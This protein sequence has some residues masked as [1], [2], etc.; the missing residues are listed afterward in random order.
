[1]SDPDYS[2]LSITFPWACR[3]ASGSGMRVCNYLP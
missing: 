3:E 2:Y 1:M